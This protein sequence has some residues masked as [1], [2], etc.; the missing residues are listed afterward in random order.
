MLLRGNNDFCVFVIITV[1]DD[2]LFIYRA[3]W[4]RRVSARGD[5]ASWTRCLL[6]GQGR[7]TS[8]TSGPRLTSL[9]RLRSVAETLAWFILLFI[10]LFNKD[11]WTKVCTIL[12]KCKVI[13]R[14]RQG[15]VLGVPAKWYAHWSLSIHPLVY[16]TVCRSIYLHV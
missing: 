4:R 9:W 8:T 11:Q 16:L 14:I 3:S 13:S 12:L 7:T 1:S 6:R 2:C 10:F 5:K 15:V